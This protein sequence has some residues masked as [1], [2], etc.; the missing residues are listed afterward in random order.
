MYRYDRGTYGAQRPS[1]FPRHVVWPS[2]GAWSRDDPR[3]L[4]NNIGRQ[5][6]IQQ[7]PLT[8]KAQG[9]QP[10]RFICHQPVRAESAVAAITSTATA[11]SL[12][13]QLRLLGDLLA[14]F[15][16]LDA[17]CVGSL[18]YGLNTKSCLQLWRKLHRPYTDRIVAVLQAIERNTE[19]HR[20]LY[21]YGFASKVENW[22]TADI[23]RPRL[24]VSCLLAPREAVEDKKRREQVTDVIGELTNAVV[25]V[26]PKIEESTTRMA[27][28]MKST[29][30]EAFQRF[31]I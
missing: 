6:L 31:S 20:L 21:S 13:H 4:H 27:E 1:P 22:W 14:R 30:T 17:T 3:F 15:Q 19:A 23:N 18:E 9:K 24:R 12:M 2:N 28:G 26:L 29:I 7:R 11:L 8:A 5:Q 16:V 10:V 25:L